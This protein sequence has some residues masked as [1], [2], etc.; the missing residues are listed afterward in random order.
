MISKVGDDDAFLR[1]F[2]LAPDLAEII[3][4]LRTRSAVDFEFGA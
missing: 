4:L 3:P 2:S 1:A